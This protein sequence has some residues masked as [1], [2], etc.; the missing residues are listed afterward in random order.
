[1]ATTRNIQMQMQY[2]NG[3]DY[4]TLYPMTNL[5]NITGSLNAINV[6]YSNSSTSSVITGDNVQL[7]ID[8]LFQSVSNGKSQI[9]S[10]ITDMGVSTSSD[11]SF[12]TMASNIKN[13]KTGVELPVEAS[14]FTYFYNS[15][16]SGLVCTINNNDLEASFVYLM[17]FIN[18]VVVN[19]RYGSQF[20]EL[21]FALLY[22]DVNTKIYNVLTGNSNY[23]PGALTQS[24]GGSVSFEPQLHRNSSTILNGNIL[25]AIVRDNRLFQ[26]I[27]AMQTYPGILL[28]TNMIY[29]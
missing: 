2:Y 15:S 1:M 20:V 27:T 16:E 10:A 29:Q 26:Y 11:A 21:G 7:A 18:T 23:S 4:D 9:A 3:T 22:P 28:K 19:I 12:S 25:T 8:Q 5:S 14:T 24:Y 6:S 17:I 13:I